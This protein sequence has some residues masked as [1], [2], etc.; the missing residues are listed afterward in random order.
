MI[1]EVYVTDLKV[2]GK[3]I[4]EAEGKYGSADVI[5]NAVIMLFDDFITKSAKKWEEMI[6]MNILGVLNSM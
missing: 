6:N 3:S 5:L 4:N 1:R 2:I